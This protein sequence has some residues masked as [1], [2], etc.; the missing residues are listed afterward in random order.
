MAVASC[1]RPC[2]VTMVVLRFRAGTRMGGQPL[3]V[4]VDGVDELQRAWLFVQQVVRLGG[5]EMGVSG[6]FS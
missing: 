4:R 3:C 2:V 1:G 6:S 5:D